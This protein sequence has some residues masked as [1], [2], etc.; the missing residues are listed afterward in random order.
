MH[1][2]RVAG[3]HGRRADVDTELFCGSDLIPA[4]ELVARPLDAQPRASEA[5]H[6]L[7]VL[8]GRQTGDAAIAGICGED[9]RPTIAP[10]LLLQVLAVG[11]SK[12]QDQIGCGG[13]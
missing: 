10:K 3:H 6:D 4:D 1:Q 5:E 12:R 2:G 8:A 13:L 7:T 9:K 11:R